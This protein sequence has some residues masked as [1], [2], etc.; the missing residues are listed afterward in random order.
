MA[1]KPSSAMKQMLRLIQERDSDGGNVL[2]FSAFREAM[3]SRQQANGAFLCEPEFFNIICNLE[4]RR[5]ERNGQAG[6]LALFAVTPL[7]FSGET[8]KQEQADLAVLQE[9][10][11][12]TLR[13]SDVLCRFGR[14]QFMALLPATTPEQG[15]RLLQRLAA[16]LKDRELQLKSRLQ[17]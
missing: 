7:D 16:G 10:L 17:P 8:A 3:Q 15:Q 1:L 2:D 5:A 6:L 4:S 13:K 11:Q 14:Q 12:D 9:V